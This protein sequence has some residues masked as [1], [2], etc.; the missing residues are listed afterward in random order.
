MEKDGTTTAPVAKTD[1]PAERGTAALPDPIRPSAPAPPHPI[2]PSPPDPVALAQL[3]AD[4]FQHL[5]TI[6]LAGAG[7]MLILV[8]TGGY[9]PSTM[10]W[11]PFTFI[12]FA[13]AAVL[14]L[15]GQMQVIDAASRGEAP[16]R[17]ARLYRHAAVF[18]IALAGGA[19]LGPVWDSAGI[20]GP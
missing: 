6:S 2:A 18:A 16:G 9:V 4:Q 1:A 11:P 3:W 7:G 12:C 14:A 5:T 8:E 10:W 15:M 19:L 17:A 13:I 20:G